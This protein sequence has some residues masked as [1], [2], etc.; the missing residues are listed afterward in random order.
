MKIKY[1]SKLRYITWV[2]ENKAHMQSPVTH[3][4]DGDR[5]PCSLQH[6]SPWEMLL[7]YAPLGH[8]KWSKI[9]GLH[10]WI[11]GNS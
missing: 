1:I 6:D 8:N 9:F 4:K 5:Q 3:I 2:R 11:I 10:K 7:I